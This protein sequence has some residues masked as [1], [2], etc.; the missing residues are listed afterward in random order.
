MPSDRVPG[1]LRGREISPAGGRTPAEQEVFDKAL[2][3]LLLRY[4]K[5]RLKENRKRKLTNAVSKVKSMRL[6]RAR[7]GDGSL[8]STPVLSPLSGSG[9]S[10]AAGGFGGLGNLQAAL[11]IKNL[12]ANL[13]LAMI[14]QQGVTIKQLA[15]DLARHVVADTRKTHQ[16]LSLAHISFPAKRDVL[17]RQSHSVSLIEGYPAYFV[18][19]LNLAEFRADKQTKWPLRF[20][21]M[22]GTHA[23]KAATE[24]E[25]HQQQR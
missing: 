14:K 8:A 24:L 13:Q 3:E 20:W 17:L 9:D 25:V 22:S 12:R 10:S 5:E 16:R 19:R 15:H 4:A 6:E 11:N 1:I 18:L 21:I 7:S 2:R 23:D